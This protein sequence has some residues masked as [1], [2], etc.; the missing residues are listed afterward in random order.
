[1][2]IGLDIKAV[3]SP[4]L[5]RRGVVNV[6]ALDAL[7]TQIAARWDRTRDSIYARLEGLL[8]RKL[9]ATDF[10][11]RLSETAYLVAMPSADGDDARICCLKIACDLHKSLLGTCNI[12]DL[13]LCR[14]TGESAQALEIVPLGTAEMIEL[15]VRGGLEELYGAVA[16]RHYRPVLQNA[17]SGTAPRFAFAPVWD[18]VH[19]AVTAYRLETHVTGA[20]RPKT[21]TLDGFKSALKLFLAGLAHTASMLSVGLDAGGRFMIVVS[22]SFDLL[23]APAGRM[24][25]AAACR[26]LPAELRPFLVFKIADLPPG[27]PQSRMSDLVCALRPFCR[28]VTVDIANGQFDK[29]NW[30][31]AGHHAL[32]LRLSALTT[33]AQAQEDIAKLAAVAKRHALTSVVVGADRLELVACARSAGINYISGTVI[34]PSIDVPL[35]MRR[36]S[37]SELRQANAL[38]A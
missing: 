35:A 37:W 33:P 27:V 1:M 4:A 9:G 18:V 22:V 36:L 3:V 13:A 5:L 8:A 32:G 11:I 16:P 14:V 6:I 38:S 15:A 29:A 10:F 24:E 19:E 21:A 17:P 34:G 7:R 31:S 28:S 23:S 20:S 30:Q 2:A 25:I 12:A 26:N